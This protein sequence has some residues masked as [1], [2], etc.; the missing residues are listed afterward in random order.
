MQTESANVTIP[1]T[2]AVNGVISVGSATNTHNVNPHIKAQTGNQM[3]AVN[4]SSVKLVS[5]VF[6]LNNSNALNNF[7][8]LESCAAT[9]TSNTKSTPV[10]V[11][12]RNNTDIASNTL[13][14][15]VDT[16]LDLKSY[17]G[18]EFHYPLYLRKQITPPYN[19]P[20]SLHLLLSDRIRK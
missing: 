15:P 3:G 8:N 19:H 11:S 17:I 10:T 14:L 2:T 18:N 13:S 7:Q 4:I 20:V 5:V 12:V 1:V 6:Q 9:F 16:T